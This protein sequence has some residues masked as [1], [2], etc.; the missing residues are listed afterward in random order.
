MTSIT[1]TTPSNV[2][3]AYSSRPSLIFPHLVSSFFPFSP[4]IY[5]GVLATHSLSIPLIEGFSASSYLSSLRARIQVGRADGWRSVGPGHGQELVVVEAFAR[6]IP[7]KSG[8]RR[9]PLALIDSTLMKACSPSILW[10]VYRGFFMR[11]SLLLLAVTTVAFF[12][13]TSIATIA[14]YLFFAPA[15]KFSP[16]PFTVP[17]SYT[18]IGKPPNQ[19]KAEGERQQRLQIKAEDEDF[20]SSPLSLS[21]DGEQ[22][23]S[24]TG[25]VTA[26]QISGPASVISGT[27]DEDDD[28][29]DSGS[30]VDVG[31]LRH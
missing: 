24:A 4:L 21:A 27:E 29:E 13:A 25:T 8:I 12:I 1:I 3:L 2:T 30:A 11:H 18:D 5:T 20:M 31:A 22:G 9:V 16:T 19:I 10:V 15:I 17:L 7:I 14:A 6:G 23:G 26:S 28:S